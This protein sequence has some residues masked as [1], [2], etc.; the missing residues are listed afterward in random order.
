MTPS[1]RT[2]PG[3]G[4]ALPSHLKPL[5][6]EYDFG[7]LRWDVDRDLVIGRIVTAGD[8]QSV[9]WLVGQ[10]GKPELKRWIV[11]QRGKGLDARQL[12]FWELALHLPH[13]AVTAWV[14]AGDRAWLRRAGG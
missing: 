1:P 11:G 12:R 8:W 10:L 2:E 9:E 7:Q 5:F 4:V 13:R 6:W 3:Q 14:A